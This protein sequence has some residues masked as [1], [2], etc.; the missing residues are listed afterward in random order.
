[1]LNEKVYPLGTVVKLKEQTERYMITGMLRPMKDGKV[2][3]YAAV[4]FP[5]GNVGAQSFRYFNHED[6]VEVLH[7]GYRHADFEKL[8][9]I[10]PALYK[11]RAEYA[12]KAAALLKEANVP[13]EVTELE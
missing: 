12:E 9:Q 8:T 5:L 10:M 6:V 13:Q 7:E 4:R 2:V 11:A 1:M 3:D